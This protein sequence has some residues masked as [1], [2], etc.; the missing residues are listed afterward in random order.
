CVLSLPPEDFAADMA[1]SALVAPAAAE[2]MDH[3]EVAGIVDLT[4]LDFEAS[5]AVGLESLER[6]VAR[7]CGSALALLKMAARAGRSAPRLW[8]ATRGAQP[9]ERSVADSEHIA[10]A[11]APLWGLG[12][13]VALEHPELWG[14]LIDLDAADSAIAALADELLD[15]DGE[16]HIAFRGSQRYVSRLEA[17]PA[18]RPVKPLELDGSR[19]YLITG[20]LGGIGLRVAAWLVERGAR[21]L[22]LVGRSAPSEA[23][24][25]RLRTLE[26]RGAR[27]RV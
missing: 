17:L 14:G 20:G 12:K 8:L 1:E 26:G 22:V 13:V 6:C 4:G 21:R 15:S 7:S 24:A 10:L 18:R 9:V 27:I 25:E 11:Q 3:G 16:D 5:H 19:S 23:A 2:L